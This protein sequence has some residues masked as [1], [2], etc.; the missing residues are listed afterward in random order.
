MDTKKFLTGTLVGG[1]AY[2]VLGFL[3]YGLLLADFFEANSGSA[4]GVMRAE[5]EMVWWALILGNL[6]FAAF[7]TY[8]FLKWAHI[9][10]FKSGLLG[11][12]TIGLLLGLGYNL[13]YYGTSN[14]MTLTGALVDVV[15]G[16]V[17]TALLGGVIGAVLHAKPSQEPVT[18]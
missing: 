6:I 17:M 12:A 2:F 16:T 1:I 7:I 14:M 18:A 13:I 4:S 15:V 11:G 3:F 8:I 10:T 9:S 5:D